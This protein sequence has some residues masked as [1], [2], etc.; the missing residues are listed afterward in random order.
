MRKEGCKK[1]VKIIRVCGEEDERGK[2][3]C[4]DCRSTK[5]EEKNG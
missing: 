1:E 3:L 5:E 4:V 2:Y